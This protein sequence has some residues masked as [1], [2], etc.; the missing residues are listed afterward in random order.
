MKSLKLIG[1]HCFLLC[2]ALCLP[3]QAKEKVVEYP[4]I[5]SCNNGTID[6]SRVELT[7]SATRL[8][9]YANYRPH[10]WIRLDSKSYLQAGGKKYMLTSAEGINPD[11][12][13][14]MPDSG[15][16][17]FTLC[18]EPLSMDTETFDFIKSDC[19]DCWKLLGVDLTGQRL[20]TPPAGLPSD[21]QDIDWNAHVPAPIFEVGTTTVKVHLLNYRPE[22]GTQSEAFVNDLYGGQHSYFATVNAET[23]EAT[24]SFLQ[25]GPVDFFI[26]N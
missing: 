10:Y 11:S 1:L 3:A 2:M 4:L 26:S 13:F 21:V 22:Q 18:F 8:C 5:Q 6:I 17:S 15:E 9:I 7:K 20:D 14:W 25:Y 24:F 12:L 19:E 23:A 16:A